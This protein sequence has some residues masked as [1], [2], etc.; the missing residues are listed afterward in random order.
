MSKKNARPRLI[1]WV[2]L[3]REFDIEIRDKKGTENLVADRLSSLHEN[4]ENK[5]SLD[6]S[7]PDDQ[8]FSLAQAETRWYADFVNYLA[9]CVVPSDLNY[10]QR[11]KIHLGS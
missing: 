5:L 3:L 8:L 9:V 1:L 4:N 11:T 10:Q 6:D 7:F 2:L